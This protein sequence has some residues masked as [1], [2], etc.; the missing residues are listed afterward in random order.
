MR[1]DMLAASE[2]VP[3]RGGAYAVE[4]PEDLGEQPYASAWDTPEIGLMEERCE[5]TRRLGRMHT[6]RRGHTW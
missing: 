4:H 6:K 5:A 2:G 3:R 1:G